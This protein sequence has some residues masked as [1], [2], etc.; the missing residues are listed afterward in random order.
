MI[1]RRRRAPM[2]ILPTIGV[3]MASVGVAL[4]IA[5]CSGGPTAGQPPRLASPEPHGARG[6]LDSPDVQAALKIQDALDAPA[7]VATM[8]RYL[9]A[10]RYADVWIS[11]NGKNGVLYVGVVHLSE[12]DQRYAADHIHTGP[13]TS[14]RLVDET[15]SKA[16]LLRYQSV[17]TSYIKRQGNTVASRHPWAGVSVSPNDNAVEFDVP[18]MDAAF[19]IKRI[20][21][22][23]PYDALVVRYQP[24]AIAS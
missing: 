13:H 24:V 10:D 8:M 1:G 12:A 21:P 18:K 9:G 17:L 7:A 22:L 6:T 4:L 2:T 19:W 15:Y 23:L 5:G 20:Q 14:F 3:L 11:N 16:Q